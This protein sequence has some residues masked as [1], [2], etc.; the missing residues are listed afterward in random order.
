MKNQQFVNESTQIRKKFV[1]TLRTLPWNNGLRTQ[2]E[3]M[4]IM[5]DQMLEFIKNSETK[6]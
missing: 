5:Y 3:S 1:N 6:I 4:L 2:A